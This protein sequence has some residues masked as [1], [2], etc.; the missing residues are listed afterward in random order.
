MK[1]RTS[2][3]VIGLMAAVLCLAPL[4]AAAQNARL[5]YREIYNIQ[6]AEQNLA[7]TFT[8]LTVSMRI[9]SA[10]ADVPISELRFNLDAKQGPIP[11]PINMD[12]SFK[13]PMRAELLEENPWLVSNQPAGTMVL[14]WNVG[15]AGK[16]PEHLDHYRPLMQPLKDYLPLQTELLKVF[17]A[18]R[19]LDIAGLRL[20]FAK[21]KD[22]PVTL[23]ARGGDRVFKPDA[24][25]AVVLPWEDALFD[26][27]PALTLPSPLESADLVTREL[28]K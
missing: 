7:R 17:P 1:S 13:V 10:R 14:E 25:H 27:N 4:M 8:N 26:E 15:L 2:R 11:V 6:Q 19:K 23:H 5:P 20:K 21:D 28:K 18:T 16:L 24:D 22:G 12:G 9:H 3:W